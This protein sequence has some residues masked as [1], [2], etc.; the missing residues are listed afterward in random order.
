[1]AKRL[2]E[3]GEE[4][5]ERVHDFT[6]GNDP[7][8]DKELVRW[9]II[10]SAAHAR[11][12]AT[13]KLISNAELH[14]LLSALKDLLKESDDGQFEIPRTL[15]D[16]HTAIESKLIAKL[17]DTGRKIHT[18]RSRNDQ[19]MLAMRLLLRARVVGVV[20]GLA[21]FSSTVL[22]KAFSTADEPMPGYTHFQPAM[23]TSV[24]MWLHAFAESA[25]A[26]IRQGLHV[27][28]SLDTNPLGAA[29]GFGVSLPLDRALVAKHLNFSRVQ[30]NPISVQNSR[31]YHELLV[32]RLIS[33]IG[34]V[35]EKFSFDMV[36]YTAREFGFFTLP[37][38][39]TTGSSIM[40]Q[41]HNPDVLELL[42][43]RAGKLRAAE[44]ELTWITSKLP[45][46]Y[47]RDF[48]YTKEPVIRSLRNIEEMLPIATEV[49]QSFG[50]N[51]EK[52]KAA[53]TSDL[54]ATYDV[55]KQVR[56][57]TPFR[58]AYQATAARI[59]K[60]DIDKESLISEFEP[61]AKENEQER[62]AAHAEL[63][64]LFSDI[65]QWR[66]LITEVETRIFNG[67]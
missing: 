55:Y 14:Q 10:G 56:A 3:K 29:S 43:A 36:L 19:V 25:I 46:H 50:I 61:I 23:P 4:L 20:E 49:V 16:C 65:A 42:R 12:L 27:L 38:S 64:E 13:Q 57:G 5:N 18:G 7:E 44:T 31:G 6:V 53:M 1:M 39:F 33:D 63:G 66:N 26:L 15:E 32:C 21:R 40:P 51:S 59:A 52:L 47:H 34:A 54:Y 17:N 45:S 2:W 30:R 48:Q 11:M 24:A 62:I 9:D 67:N 28:D 8:I 60:D 41:K 37:T 35:I 58:D 22:T